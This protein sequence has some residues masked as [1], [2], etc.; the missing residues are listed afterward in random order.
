MEK[1]WKGLNGRT[2]DQLITYF[3]HMAFHLLHGNSGSNLRLEFL[4][5]FELDYLLILGSFVKNQSISNMSGRFAKLIRNT[6]ILQV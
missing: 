2:K 3:T 6:I 1:Y 4:K 5:S